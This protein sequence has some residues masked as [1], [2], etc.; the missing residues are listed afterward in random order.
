MSKDKMSFEEAMK[1]LEKI[2]D[3][4][5]KGEYTLE[6]SLKMFEDGVKLG[7]RCKE[8]LEKAEIRVRKLAGDDTV[9]ELDLSDDL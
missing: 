3:A 9:E 8:I 1:E 2:V 6:E 4:L 5:D 7:K